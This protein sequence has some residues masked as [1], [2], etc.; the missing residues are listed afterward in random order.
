MG[1]G[2]DFTEKAPLESAVFQRGAVGLPQNAASFATFDYCF[3]TVNLAMEAR[4]NYPWGPEPEEKH[5]YQ[6]ADRIHFEDLR[7]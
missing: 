6:R 7:Q 3:L 5:A 4:M 1:E 2:Q